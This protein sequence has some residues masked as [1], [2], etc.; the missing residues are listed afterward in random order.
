MTF[1]TDTAVVQALQRALTHF[2]SGRIAEAKDLCRQILCRH[3]DHAEALHLLGIMTSA[4]G[5]LPSGIE[6]IRRCLV[7]RPDWAEA[8]SNLANALRS[9]GCLD[10]SI[11]ASRTALKLMPDNWVAHNNLGVALCDRGSIDEAITAY[12][13]AIQLNPGYAEA[14]SNLANALRQAGNFDDAVAACGA[15]LKINPH[16]AEA[17]RNLGDILKDQNRLDEALA[18]Y[19]SALQI[20]PGDPDAMNNLGICFADKG[21]HD[22]AI[23][24]FGRAIQ[25]SPEFSEAHN[26]LGNALKNK[27]Q[28]EDAVSA[29][30]RAIRLNPK[31]AEARNNLG[32]ALHD[33]GKFDDSHASFMEALILNPKYAEALSNLGNLLL[34]RGQLDE[35]VRVF[36]RAIELRPELAEAHTNLGNALKAGGQLEDAIKAYEQAVL[37]QPDNSRFQSN[38][39]YASLFHPEFS[40]QAIRRQ[41]EDWNHRHGR[42]AA[43]EGTRHKNDP[44]PDRP[45]RIGYISPNFRDHVIGRN[46][47]PL[48]REHDRTRFEIVCYARLNRRDEFTP[49]FESV[50]DE[51]RDIT[52]MS[53]DRVAQLIMEDRI[54]ILIDLAM[55]LSDNALP[56]LALKPA[57]IQIAFAAYPGSTGLDAMNYR[58]TDP[59]LDTPG[60]TDGDYSERSIYLAETF[61]CYE[62]P[63]APPITELA[64]I[65]NGYITFGCLCEFCKINPP[66]MAL[67]AN[68]LNQTPNSRLLLLAPAGDSRQRVLECFLKFDIGMERLIFVARQPRLEYLRT[69]NLIDIGLDTLPYNGH[70]TSLDAAWM[71]VPVV[72]CIGQTVAGRAGWS[73]LSNLGLPELAA[74]SQE[75]FVA[76]AT[77]LAADLPK[78]SQ[79]RETLRRRMQRSPLMDAPR[80][81]RNVED[82]YRLA[83][84]RWCADQQPAPQ[85]NRVV[86]KVG[87]IAHRKPAKAA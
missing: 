46:V 13:L 48:L 3:V 83:W 9:A 32:V 24:V 43:T 61:W 76:I 51:W 40:T 80:F 2:E 28:V 14:H 25:L 74:R 35:A 20:N 57:P 81:S 64:A 37:L 78:L 17:H 45:L 7:A 70:T 30:A 82:A 65:S 54:D 5:D 31:F 79:L 63:E 19:R 66:L 18:A 26:N 6:L 16:L 60:K 15:A 36:T 71:G 86:V 53:D 58:L 41:L 52:G 11:A 34:E 21:E 39:V 73:Q 38:L 47:L 75:E 67:W 72:S 10:E 42:H 44:T 1:A 77:N 69:Y 27:G 50:S 12:R 68:V 23:A 59:Q 33:L 22:A 4:D 62:S 8:R 87:P 84:R 49:V 85:P 56:I 29:Y 55:H